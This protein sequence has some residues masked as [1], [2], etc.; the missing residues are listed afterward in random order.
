M[1][2]IELCLSRE[3]AAA[4]ST[5]EVFL[6]DGTTGDSFN[7]GLRP[8][9]R[10]LGTVPSVNADFV[11]VSLAVYVADHSVLRQRGGS[12]WNQRHLELSVP[13][14]HRDE[15]QA[16]ASSFERTLAFLTG[17][18]W[19]LQFTPLSP[20]ESSAALVPDTAVRTVLVSGGADSASG[21]LVSA[22]SLASGT[23]QRLV[24]HSSSGSGASAPQQRVASALEELFPGTTVHHHQVH[25]QRRSR[26]LDGTRYRREPS[27]RSRSLLFLALGLAV[28]SQSGRGLWI[29]ENGFASINPPLGP[30]RVGALSTR[31]T[32]PWFLWRV[33]SLLTDL[34]GFGQIENP[35]QALTKGDEYRRVADLVGADRA[36]AFLSSTN[37]CSHS[38]QQYLGKVASGS[39]CGKCFGCVLRRAAFAAAD[40][41]DAT[42]YLA[43]RGG[44]YA[45]YAEQRSIETAVRDFLDA[46]VDESFLM[47]TPLP[48]ELSVSDARTL[49]ARGLAEL[50]KYLG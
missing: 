14:L 5:D 7:T 34:G 11:R 33:G 10:Q 49:Y 46:G 50:G 18:R 37:S 30:E 44:R 19:T 27:S 6:W 43:E 47:T 41:P 21:A 20:P 2:S 48:P 42:P 25:L 31:T 32:Q 23:G 8:D 15:W 17:D 24:S 29:A 9:L 4:S 40:L 12:N 35:F 36:A 39:H 38:D 1:T 26:R 28:A 22:A 16:S 45:A 3:E 13:V